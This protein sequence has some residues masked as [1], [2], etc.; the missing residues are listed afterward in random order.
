[1]RLLVEERWND[2]FTF[3]NWQKGAPSPAIKPS[4]PHAD[5]KFTLEFGA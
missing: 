1:M 5:V 3:V 2:T 4:M